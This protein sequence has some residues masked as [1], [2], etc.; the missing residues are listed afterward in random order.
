VKGEHR[1]RGYTG[2]DLQREIEFNK[3][4]HASEHEEEFMQ[5]AVEVTPPSGTDDY[6]GDLLAGTLCF[7]WT[8]CLSNSSSSGKYDFGWTN[9][10]NQAD[11]GPLTSANHPGIQSFFTGNS[12]PSGTSRLIA[13]Q[14]TGATEMGFTLGDG[15]IRIGGW[16]RVPNLSDGTD[17]YRV[18]VGLYDAATAT[19]GDSV[20]IMYTDGENS[21][22]WRADVSTG[23]T[24]TNDAL[25]DSGGA[26]TVATN[27]WYKLEVIIN[28]AG[29]SADFYINSV[30]KGTIAT[31][32]PSGTIAAQVGIFKSAG[33]TS[34]KVYVDA[35]WVVAAIS[36]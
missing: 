9:V 10:G 5:T 7:C 31:G 2:R 20:S 34:R 32:F 16:L 15:Q 18:V 4:V 3:K 30:L 27:T 35:A 12:A 29:T 26:V 14:V 8:D 19:P 24:R 25:D 11:D 23:G 33:N 13:G 36:R 17:T 1:I 22:A 28:A 21:G 6:L